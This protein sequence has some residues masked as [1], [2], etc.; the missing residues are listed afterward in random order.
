MLEIPDRVC[1]VLVCVLEAME[2]V[3]CVLEAV[4]GV[5]CVLKV[6]DGVRCTSLSEPVEG[7]LELLELAGGDA[8]YAAMQVGARGGRVL[9]G[10]GRGWCALFAGGAK[11]D[12]LYASQYTVLYAEGIGGRT[13][14]MYLCAGDDVLRAGAAGGDALS[15]AGGHASN[16]VVAE[17]C[18]PRAGRC[19]EPA[20]R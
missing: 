16:A 5:L 2:G 8:L 7:M 19:G 9:C 18:A 11:G 14:L 1:S 6:T 20:L 10:G 13:I 3:C 17:G 12:A 4:K 15:R